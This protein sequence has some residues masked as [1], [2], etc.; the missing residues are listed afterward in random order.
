MEFMPPAEVLYTPPPASKRRR[1]S[2]SSVLRRHNVRM[3]PSGYLGRSYSKPFY[4]VF[5]TTIYWSV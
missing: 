5:V 2:S 1:G 4:G 3:T